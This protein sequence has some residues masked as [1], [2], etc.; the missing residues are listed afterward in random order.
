LSL[1]LDSPYFKKYG[2]ST[3]GPLNPISELNGRLHSLTGAFKSI[4]LNALKAK[5]PTIKLNEQMWA[6]VDRHYNENCECGLKSKATVEMVAQSIFEEQNEPRAQEILKKKGD[7]ENWDFNTCLTYVKLLFGRNTLQG[8]SME[9][10]AIK[11]L[12]TDLWRFELEIANDELDKK[13]CVDIVVK[14]KSSKE[15]VGGIQVKPQS[16]YHTGTDHVTQ[17]NKKWDYPVYHL[18][19]DDMESKN[20]INRLEVLSKFL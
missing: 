9:E 16:Y 19:Y 6:E 7:K 10:Q 14:N 11:D 2:K 12:S 17:A 18:K 20:W 15:I 3:G 5:H 13:Y 1:N 8:Q 4:S